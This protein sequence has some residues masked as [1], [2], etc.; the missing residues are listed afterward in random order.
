M[1]DETKTGPPEQEDWLENMSD[2]QAREAVLVML[3][4]EE[5]VL[6]KLSNTEQG[7]S[8]EDIERGKIIVNARDQLTGGNLTPAMEF[9]IAEKEKVAARIRER[10]EG[11]ARMKEVDPQEVETATRQLQWFESQHD[12]QTLDDTGREIWE[13]LKNNQEKLT[14]SDEQHQDAQELDVLEAVEASLRQQ[15][16]RGATS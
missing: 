7:L 8:K 16:A 2:A 15:Q 11:G 4:E 6:L 12:T 13:M 5:G 9:V 14:Q 10:H 1:A 3:D